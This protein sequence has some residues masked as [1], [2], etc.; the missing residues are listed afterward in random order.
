MRIQDTPVWNDPLVQ[1]TIAAI[2]DVGEITQDGD[3][4]DNPV[5]RILTE[6]GCQDPLAVCT[7]LGDI[8]YVGESL[9]QPVQAIAELVRIERVKEEG[10]AHLFAAGS[11]TPLRIVLA[12]LAAES[13]GDAFR[14]ASANGD[15]K[16][17]RGLVISAADTV[18]DLADGMAESGLWKEIP[19]KLLEKFM[20]SAENI[21]SLLDSPSRKKVLDMA[22]GNLKTLAMQAAVQEAKDTTPPRHDP[23]SQFEACKKLA[24]TRYR[25]GQ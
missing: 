15:P 14:E 6:T 10:T 8:F 25:L 5:M 23:T 7:V 17:L 2:G 12:S 22:V 9:P 16:E 13:T 4:S 1:E 11:A 24:K 19:P 18:I 21:R 3:I 20:E